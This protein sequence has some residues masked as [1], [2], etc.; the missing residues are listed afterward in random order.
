[1][2][3]SELRIKWLEDDDGNALRG[4]LRVGEA[5]RES[6][7]ISDRTVK[8][9]RLPPTERDLSNPERFA[10]IAPESTAR[11]QK[12]THLQQQIVRNSLRDLVNAEDWSVHTP[13][14]G[15]EPAYKRQKT[16][17]VGLGGNPD[18]DQPLPSSEGAEEVIFQRS[19]LRISQ[20]APAHQVDDSQRSPARKRLYSSGVLR[21]S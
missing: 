17:D 5:F 2:C 18:R 11:P 4:H 9:V 16:G 20:H 13:R 21:L 6:R 14:D 10:S 1:M 8:V 12:R 19:G 3:N 15:Y 7:D